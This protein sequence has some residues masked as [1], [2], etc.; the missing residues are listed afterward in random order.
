MR[1]DVSDAVTHFFMETPLPWFYTASSVVLI[2]K[3]L[4][5]SGFDKFR[6]IRLCSLVYKLC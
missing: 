4:S 3:I 2:L 1:K 5:P 6:P